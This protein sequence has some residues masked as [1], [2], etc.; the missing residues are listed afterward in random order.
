MLTK[1]DI[2][3]SCQYNK[4][5]QVLMFSPSASSRLPRIMSELF[6]SLWAEGIVR[7]QQKWKMSSLSIDIIGATSYSKQLPQ[8]WKKFACMEKYGQQPW[9]KDRKVHDDF[10]ILFLIKFSHFT[11]KNYVGLLLCSKSPAQECWMLNHARICQF[12]HPRD[13]HKLR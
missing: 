8:R 13:P 4:G 9:Y 12:T 3:W 1:K 7:T 2:R 6:F 5:H 10:M 11:I